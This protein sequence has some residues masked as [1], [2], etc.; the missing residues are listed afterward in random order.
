MFSSEFLV[1]AYIFW[2]VI[3]FE[4]IVMYT[5]KKC[6]NSLIEKTLLSLLTGVDNLVENQLIVRE[7]GFSGLSI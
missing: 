3:Y 7:K 6:F 4:F 5:E 1:L 2:S